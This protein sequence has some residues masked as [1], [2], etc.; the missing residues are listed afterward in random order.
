MQTVC[1][2]TAARSLDRRAAFPNLTVMR[3]SDARQIAVSPPAS[4]SALDFTDRQKRR[5]CLPQDRPY[6]SDRSSMRSARLTVPISADQIGR[7]CS[8]SCESVFAWIM[9]ARKARAATCHVGGECQCR[10]VEQCVTCEFRSPATEVCANKITE[11]LG[12]APRSRR[13]PWVTRSSNRWHFP[14]LCL[15]A[16]P[17]LCRS[18]GLPVGSTSTTA[19][20]CH[21]RDD[22]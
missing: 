7:A 14:T 13:S 22:C 4:H 2:W 10:D 12:V 11:L 19:S 16:L 3:P 15:L 8:S 5:A 1:G 20:D 17:A 18:G 9:E 21:S 6:R